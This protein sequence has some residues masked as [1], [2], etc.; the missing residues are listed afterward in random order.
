MTPCDHHLFTASV[1]KGCTN[2]FFSSLIGKISRKKLAVLLDFV[3]ITSPLPSI[4]TTCTTFFNLGRYLPI[5]IP[6][7]TNYTVCEKWTKNLGR[8]L[9]PFIW[10][11]SKRTA[12]F[13]V[14]PSLFQLNPTYVYEMDSKL[15]PS[16]N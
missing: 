3:Q 15:G 13:F 5:P 8:A 6:E 7:L 11:K 10:T 16:L 2:W 12:T 1:R 4:W 9:H 14:K